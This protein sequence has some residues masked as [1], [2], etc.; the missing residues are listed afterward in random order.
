VNQQ[1]LGSRAIRLYLQKLGGERMLCFLANELS[2]RGYVVYIF[3]S[4]APCASSFYEIA[5]GVQW[6]RLIFSSGVRDI[7]DRKNE[8]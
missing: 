7:V 2:S 4:D 1:A 6:H 8:I 5:D 3:S